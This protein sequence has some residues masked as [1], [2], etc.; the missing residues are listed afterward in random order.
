MCTIC[1]NLQSSPPSS[2]IAVASLPL[3]VLLKQENDIFWIISGSLLSASAGMLPDPPTRPFL[4]CLIT[5]LYLLLSWLCNVYSLINWWYFWW[6]WWNMSVFGPSNAPSLTCHVGN[7]LVSL[8]NCT[9][10]TD[11][12][13]IP[14]MFLAVSL[15]FLILLLGH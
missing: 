9:F 11:C 13:L 4:S 12:I 8:G 6:L 10:L 5:F 3:P 1:I 14:F 2:L 7:V 15:L